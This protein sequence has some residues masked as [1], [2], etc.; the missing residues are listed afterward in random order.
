MKNTPRPRSLHIRMSLV[1]S[2]LVAAVG[3]ASALVGCQSAIDQGVADRGSARY[4]ESLLAR[5][6]LQNTYHGDAI[7]DPTIAQGVRELPR[8]DAAGPAVAATMEAAVAPNN[9]A[10]TTDASTTMPA[11]TATSEPVPAGNAPLPPNT[12]P[13]ED[14]RQHLRRGESGRTFR[15]LAQRPGAA[16]QSFASGSH[17]PHAQKRARHPHAGLRPSDQGSARNTAGCP[18]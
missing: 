12:L 5:S 18:L 6:I 8:V 4:S 7:Q 13:S 17:L 9:I 16:V 10:P 2:V 3:S 15:L 11:A 14:T 1:N